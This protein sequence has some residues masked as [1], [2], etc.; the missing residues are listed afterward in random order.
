[1][2][3]IDVF[4]FQREASH[5][6]LQGENPY[7]LRL[8]DIYGPRHSYY[9]EEQ[10]RDG[11]LTFGFIYPPLSL[12]LALPG[13]LIGNDFR[14]SQLAAMAG[15][16]LLMGTAR[17]GRLGKAAAVLY[18]FTPRVF[19]VLEMG[20]TEPFAVLLASA[21]VFCAT[22]GLV[23]PLPFVL[24]CLFA[25]KQHLV[26]T[27]LLTPLL[28]PGVSAWRR[29]ARTTIAAVSF[30]A[31][32]TLPFLLWDPAAFIRSVVTVQLQNPFRADA[33]SYAALL[34]REGFVRMPAWVPFALVLPAAGIGLWRG[35]RSASGFA[36]ASALLYFA[37][38]AFAKQAFCNYYFFL[39]GLLC[40]AISAMR[41]PQDDEL[42][43]S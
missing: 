31:L 11:W 39:L 22:R 19:Y 13:H 12:L 24:G 23:R 27:A 14:Y 17:P 36:G 35:A 30:A 15:A 1:M 20:W 38:F 16:A 26:L 21:T 40:C 2:P 41:L 8:P 3:L 18:L 43:G 4:L 28:H 10:A 33:L 5:A 42:H 29:A 32:L 37:F 7:S 34:V 25:V 9:T 6:L